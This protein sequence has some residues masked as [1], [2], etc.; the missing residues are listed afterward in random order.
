M[1]DE[2]PQA[3]GPAVQKNADLDAGHVPM[4][5]E[6][7][8]AKWT[9]PPMGVVAIVLAV[10]AIIVGLVSYGMRPTAAAT[11]SIDEAFAV[12]LPGDN[13]LATMKVTLN[14]VGGKPLWIKNVKAKLAT[15]KG[16]FEDDAANAV[17]FERYFLGFP[18]L[19]N[20]SISPLKVETKMSPG[21]QA[22]G[23]IIVAFPV[24]VDQFNNR[25]SLTV[26]VVPYDQKA[27]VI[28]K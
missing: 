12:A 14:N 16:E 23:S 21:E 9:M 17:D 5:E 27:I 10:I 7:D 18:D 2:N 13:V 24:T 3:T 19:R 1:A 11:G 15:D 6:F 26:T 25:K 4:S 22:R 8:R 20:H 28:Q